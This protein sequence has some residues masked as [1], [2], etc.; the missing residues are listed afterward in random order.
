MSIHHGNRSSFTETTSLLLLFFLLLVQLQS[1][2]FQLDALPVV[3][4]LLLLRQEGYLPFKVAF[5]LLH[6]PE[7]LW[8]RGGAA[9]VAFV[10]CRSSSGSWR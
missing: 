4:Q 1:Q 9:V 2:S 10:R 6:L 7:Q 8:D 3:L 5:L